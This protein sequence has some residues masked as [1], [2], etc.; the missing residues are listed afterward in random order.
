MKKISVLIIL[1]IVCSSIFM[2]PVSAVEPQWIFE[3]PKSVIPVEINGDGQGWEDAGVIIANND[4]PVFQQFGMWQGNADLP[5]PSSELSAEYRLKWDETYFYILEKRFDKNHVIFDDINETPENG[6]PWMH[7]GTLF[8]LNYDA[9]FVEPT[10]EGCYEIFWVNNGETL[11]MTGRNVDKAHMFPGDPEMEGIL[12]AGSRDGDTY[13]TEVA[14]PWATMKKVSG[15]P[16]P[17]EGLKLRMTPV[18]SAFNAKTTDIADRFQAEIWNQLN[19]YTDPEVA[20]P[21][22]PESNGGMILVGATYTTP[23]EPEPVVDDTAMGGGGETENV[24]TPEPAPVAPVTTAPVTGDNN[25]IIIAMIGLLAAVIFAV[26]KRGFVKN[27][28]A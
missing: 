4:N 24:H 9:D 13:I 2:I 15:F 22:D 1:A 10:R 28:I 11:V 5:I 3:C 21:D 20:G 23:A 6:F 26:G 14:V 25:I 16:D 8:F 27:F 7:S 19:F 17:S 18:L 12:I